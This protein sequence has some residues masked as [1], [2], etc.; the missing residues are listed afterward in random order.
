MS[1]RELLEFA[2][3][4]IGGIYD[5]GHI[6]LNGGIDY[7]EWNPLLNGCDTLCLTVGL[8]IDLE[9]SGNRVFAFLPSDEKQWR[10]RASEISTDHKGDLLSAARRAIV[11]AA[12]EIGKHM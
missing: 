8:K 6:S 3:K 1:D 5:A 4:A 10:S 12:A 2:A 7:Q 11:R 9:F